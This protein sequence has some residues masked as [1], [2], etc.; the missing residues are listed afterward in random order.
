MTIL[1]SLGYLNYL[2]NFTLGGGAILKLNYL[3]G[4]E[5][6]FLFVILSS[7]GLSIIYEIIK[8]KTKTNGPLLM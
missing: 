4:K 2:S 6:I 7:F 5:F 1:Y 8:E 3:I